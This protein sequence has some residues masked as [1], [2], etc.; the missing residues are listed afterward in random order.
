MDKRTSRLPRERDAGHN[1]PTETTTVG[2][3][4]K[5]AKCHSSGP[6]KAAAIDMRLFSI[7]LSMVDPGRYYQVRFK[8]ES[9]WTRASRW[10]KLWL[11]DG[12]LVGR[13]EN[14]AEVR[15]FE[16]EVMATI[17]TV[18]RRLMAPLDNGDTPGVKQY[19][20]DRDLLDGCGDL[21]G[22]AV[23]NT[24]HSSQQQIAVYRAVRLAAAAKANPP[25]P[26]SEL[27][28]GYCV[29]DNDGVTVF[30]CLELEE[31]VRYAQNNQFDRGRNVGVVFAD[32]SL[33]FGH[34]LSL[35]PW[36]DDK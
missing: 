14:T 27:L 22:S 31:A 23:T 5:D 30:E 6:S 35:R 36:I 18:A 25:A 3:G 7:P 11:A 13:V 17:D 26:H 8:G 2:R 24:D 33:R 20:I 15:P 28:V 1:N 9:K 12:D 32:G 34:E 4:K 19:Y 16:Q 21:L 10:E 29:T